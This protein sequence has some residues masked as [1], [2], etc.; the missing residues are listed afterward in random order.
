MRYE[1]RGRMAVTLTKTFNLIT[2][3]AVVFQFQ[4]SFIRL[5]SVYGKL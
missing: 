3:L 4:L 1:L 2:G 5:I